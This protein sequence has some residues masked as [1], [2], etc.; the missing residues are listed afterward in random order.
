MVS[1]QADPVP[2]PQEQPT[3]EPQPP[4]TPVPDAPEPLEPTP[5]PAAEPNS[6]PH[7]PPEASQGTAPPQSEPPT[8]PPTVQSS[9]TP[10]A[11]APSS[12]QPIATHRAEALEKRMVKKR[13]KLEK[14][15]AHARSKRSITNNNVQL[16][17]HVS[18]ATATRYLSELV[19]RGSL[20]R[21]G[22]P[23]R[24]KYEPA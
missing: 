14:I 17:L 6:P 23:K 7:A 19:R 13:E 3:A 16:L 2:V 9:S 22:A 11:F 21:V 18:D 20:K 12:A 1:P 24:P 10:P 4:A 8:Q 5:E 15:V